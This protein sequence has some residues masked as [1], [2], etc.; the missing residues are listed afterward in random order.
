MPNA[1]PILF[2]RFYEIASDYNTI[3]F[4]NIIICFD[5]ILTIKREI[6]DT[7]NAYINCGINLNI[8]RFTIITYCIGRDGIRR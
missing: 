4:K 5:S 8:F 6:V 7:Y 3:L 1:A 2:E